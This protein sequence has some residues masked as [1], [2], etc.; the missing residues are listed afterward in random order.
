M[1]INIRVCLGASI[2]GVFHAATPFGAIIGISVKTEVIMSLNVVMT[3][4]VAG[5]ALL[6]RSG[7]GSEI[8]RGRAWKSVIRNLG[9]RATEGSTS[10][11]RTI[12]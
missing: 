2:A 10:S 1:K 6:R 7:D 12:F 4:L 11:L 3:S 5:V 8:R 9:V